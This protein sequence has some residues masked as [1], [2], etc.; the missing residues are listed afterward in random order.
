MSKWGGTERIRREKRVV[1]EKGKGRGQAEDGERKEKKKKKK[2]G[3]LMG[4]GR[5][6]K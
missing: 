6:R 2:E 4:Y 1:G 3:Y 5:D